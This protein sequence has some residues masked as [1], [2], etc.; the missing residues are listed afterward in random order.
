[1]RLRF[2][3]VL[4][5]AQALFAIALIASN[6]SPEFIQATGPLGS[7]YFAPRNLPASVIRFVETNLPAVPVVAPIYVLVGGRER[8][9]NT[10]WLIAAFGLAGMGIWFFVGQ[11]LDDVVAAAMKRLDPRRHVFDRLFSA[12]V[13]A[14]A[15]A[16]F[17]ES[18]VASFSLSLGES[19]VRVDA[20]CWIAFGCGALLVQIGWTRKAKDLGSIMQNN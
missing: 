13:V 3:L 14:S 16:V 2:K 1:M 11:F 6:R 17:V 12:F 4:P 15:C 19:V 5:V 9:G 8:P 10:Q 18:D 20:L 7:T